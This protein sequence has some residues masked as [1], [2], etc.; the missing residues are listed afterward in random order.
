MKLK[1]LFAAMLS[2]ILFTGCSDDIEPAG[3]LGNMGLSTTYAIIPEAGGT[4][5]VT[6]TASEDWE[7]QNVAIDDQTGNQVLAKEAEPIRDKDGKTT[8]SWFKFSQL[9]G[10]PEVAGQTFTTTLEISAPVTEYGREFELEIRVGDNTQFLK[11]RQGSMEATTATCAEV[12]SGVEGKTYRVKGVCTAISNTT[13]G[14]WYLNDGTGQV[15]IYGTLDSEGATKNFASL[16]IEV[17]DEVEVEGPKKTYG[18]DIELVDVTVIKVTKWLL[19]I[20]TPDVTLSN[21]AQ[22][23][24]VKVAYK[25]KGVF[26][27]IPEEAQSWVRYTKTEF[28]AGVPTKIEPSPADTAVFK[29]NVAENINLTDTRDCKLTF[30]SSSADGTSAMTYGIQQGVLGKTVAEFLALP[31]DPNTPYRI[32]GVI[33]KIENDKYGN[34]R[35]KDATG[36]VL[37][38]GT[39]TPDGQSKQFA[40]LGLKEGDVIA[41]YGPKVSHNGNPQMKNGTYESHIDVTPISAADFRNVE[42]SKTK[43]YMLTGKVE[44][45]TESGAKDDIVT[46]GNFNLTDESGSVYVYGVTTGWNGERKKFGTLGVGY[47]DEITIIAYKDTYKGL[48]EAVGTYVSHKKAE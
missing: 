10:D 13:Y 16:N 44:K 48:V 43:Y 39:L 47:G 34:I 2:A 23:I 22:E 3:Q 12:I 9:S 7:I 14:N 30:T 29:F 28:V 20:L 4:A 45:V 32:E 11:V 42:D 6:I 1:Y 18:S 46:Y 8:E 17:G 24:E 41:I 26:V 25:G 36:E 19:K 21:A 40:S 27:D 35:V 38:Y 15:Y 37:V 5:T 31:D 33:T